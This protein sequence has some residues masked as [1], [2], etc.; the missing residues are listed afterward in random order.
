MKPPAIQVRHAGLV[1]KDLQRALWFY[2]ELLG[3]EEQRR[4]VEQGPVIENM[5]GL[6][7][8][9]VETVK[10]GTKNGITQIELLSFRS[11]PVAV[12]E[13]HRTLMVGLTHLAFT[14]DN[15]PQLYA[16]LTARGILFQYP[17]QTS[18]DGR[19][20]LAYCRDPEGTWVELVEVL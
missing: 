6:K 9:E 15:L 11:H 10:L 8:V 5:L 19:F 3:L 13:N 12:L 2:R 4:M 18:P 7:D 17:P 14:V 1:V 20:R 16:E